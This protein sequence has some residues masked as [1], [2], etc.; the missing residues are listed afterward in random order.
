MVQVPNICGLIPS[1]PHSSSHLITFHFHQ[2]HPWTYLSDTGQ[3]EEEENDADAK[4]QQHL[5]LAQVRELVAEAR[6]QALE[7]RKLTVKQKAYY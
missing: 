6:H 7:R 4:R 1:A 3:T 5:V 2:T